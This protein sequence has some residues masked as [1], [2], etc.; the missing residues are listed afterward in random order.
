[1]ASAATWSRWR[2]SNP[3][4]Q[5]G[6]L[7]FCHW[8]TPAYP[9]KF[10]TL[11]HSLLWFARENFRRETLGQIQFLGSNFWEHRSSWHYMILL[12]NILIFGFALWCKQIKYLAVLAG[13]SRTRRAAA[14][15]T[16][17]GRALS[18]TGWL[19]GGNGNGKWEIGSLYKITERDFRA[20]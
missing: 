13:R 11:Y 10:F 7:T 14:R 3:R 4:V 17:L 18:P 6:K 15:E 8:T 2:E 19:I 5:L 9:L 12:Y 1:M 16:T 20:W